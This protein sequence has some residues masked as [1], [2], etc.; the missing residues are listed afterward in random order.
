MRLHL[1][2][3]AEFDLP[4]AKPTLALLP[5]VEMISPCYYLCLI[6]TAWHNLCVCLV[7]PLDIELLGVGGSNHVTQLLA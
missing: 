1:L 5:L 3:L 2:P 4:H 7:P 6:A